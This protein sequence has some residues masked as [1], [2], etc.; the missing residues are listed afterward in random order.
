MTTLDDAWAWYSAV[1]EGAKRL[2][3]L[4]KFW[5]DLP[6][7]E[8]DWVRQIERN[9]VLGGLEA[10]QMDKD[11]RRVTKELDDLA[12]LVLFSV[13][14]AN[15]R[16]LVERQVRPE[17]DRLVHAALTKAGEEVLQRISEGSFF[18]VLELLKS[19]IDS[20]LIEEVNQ[21]RRFRNWVAHGRRP[22]KPGEQLATVDPEAAFKRLKTFLERLSAAPTTASDAQTLDGPPV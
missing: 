5:N 14:E 11:S 18:R 1:A 21:V 3:H 20:A 9:G 17:V 8:H 4:A 13:F 16:D 19:Q 6:W 22:L 10:D 2:A 12:V 7:G 15:V